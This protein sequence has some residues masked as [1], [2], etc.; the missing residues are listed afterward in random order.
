[1]TDDEDEALELKDRLAIY[2]FDDSS[3][4][5]N[6]NAHVQSC[7]CAHEILHLLQKFKLYYGVTTCVA[8]EAEA[9]QGEQSRK[10]RRNEPS[11]IENNSSAPPGKKVRKSSSV[12]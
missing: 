1:M 6:G 5:H 9:T 12:L 7:A 8:M 4:E 10:K 3:L 11:K 2:N